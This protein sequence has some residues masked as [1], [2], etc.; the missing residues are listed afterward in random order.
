MGRKKALKRTAE[1]MEAE[2]PVSNLMP[3]VLAVIC[4]IYL[5]LSY[6]RDVL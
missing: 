4:P 2:E 3:Q 1:E 5:S 6:L